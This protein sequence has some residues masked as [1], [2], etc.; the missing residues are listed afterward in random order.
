MASF[1]PRGRIRAPG[2]FTWEGT[3]H[4][5]ESSGSWGW[6]VVVGD[7]QLHICHA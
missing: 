5:S 3:G 1:S 7:L 6:C 4:A 2:L